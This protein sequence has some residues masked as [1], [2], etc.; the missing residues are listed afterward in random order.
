M[1]IDTAGESFVA[2]QREHFPHNEVHAH[3]FAHKEKLPY[4]KH[5]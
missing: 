5:I 4:M 2:L 1:I 3:Q